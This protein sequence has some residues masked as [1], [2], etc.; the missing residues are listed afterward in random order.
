MITGRNAP[1]YGERAEENIVLG[2]YHGKVV[3]GVYGNGQNRLCCIAAPENAYPA[4]TYV[5]TE[6]LQPLSTLDAGEAQAV[7]E[8]FKE[9]FVQYGN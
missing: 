9:A 8:T 7:T 3:V 5:D 2:H 1:D 6:D 4:G